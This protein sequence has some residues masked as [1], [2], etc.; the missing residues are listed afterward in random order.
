[1]PS[2]EDI[3]CDG[4]VTFTIFNLPR[5]SEDQACISQAFPPPSA[6]SVISFI[7]ADHIWFIANVFSTDDLP[8]LTVPS[9]Y[10][11]LLPKQSRRAWRIV[12]LS[13]RHPPSKVSLPLTRSRILKTLKR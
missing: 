10:T 9:Q 5:M 13:V 1:M 11:S 2:G 7:N 6:P 12:H 8:Q 4:N 3:E